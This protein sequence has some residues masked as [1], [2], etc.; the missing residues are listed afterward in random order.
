[1]G[2]NQRVCYECGSPY[3]FHNTCPKLNRT[4]SQVGNRLTIEGNQNPRNN[5]NQ[6]RGRA[7]NVNTVEARQDPNVMTGTFSLN[8]HF[9]TVLFDLGADFS[10]ISTDFVSLL[11][12][13]PSTLRPSYVIKIANGEKNHAAYTDRFHELE[14]LVPHLVTP[15][16]KRID[17]RE[18]VGK[19]FMKAVP[20]RNEYA[21]SHPGII[22]GC[23]LEL[24][25]FLFTIDLIPFGHGCFDVTVGM[26]WFFRH[27]AE[28]VCHEKVVRI[29]LASGKILLVVDPKERIMVLDALGI[30]WTTLAS[31]MVLIDREPSQSTSLLDSNLC[32]TQLFVEKLEIELWNLKVKGNDVGG[33]TQRFQELALMCTKFI[34]NETEKVDKYISGLPDNIHGNVMAARPKTLDDAIEFANDLMD[35]KLCTYAERQTENKRK[36]NN[37]NQ[38]QQQLL[39]KQNVVQA[40]A[41]APKCTNCKK[42]GHLA[43]DCWHPINVNNQRTITC[44]ECGNQGNYRSDCPVLKNQCT[45]ARGMVYALGEG[46]TN[47][48]LDNTEDDIN[49]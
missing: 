41:G 22:H 29:P 48:D 9:A 13:K 15:K 1:M 38:A 45:E 31:S 26:D 34:S 19:G 42:I 30:V 4:P 36:L 3:H 32:E 2:N 17:R 21:G 25:D 47:Q 33:Y 20:T 11:N 28:I 5:G 46:E 7:F 40:Y 8:D 10:F 49:A 27:K 18:K 37:N 6:A 12:V 35:Q 16:S 23:I 14:K 24:G 44:Y 39:R 43:K